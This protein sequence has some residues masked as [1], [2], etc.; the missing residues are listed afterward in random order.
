MLYSVKQSRKKSNKT[1]QQYSTFKICCKTVSSLSFVED[2][3]WVKTN[4]SL[5]IFYRRDVLDE[6]NSYLLSGLGHILHL[7]PKMHK[8]ST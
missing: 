3:D 8:L 1:K 6:K 4:Q 5:S 7:C 2:R